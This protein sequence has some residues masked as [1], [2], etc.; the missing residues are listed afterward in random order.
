MC[1]ACAAIFNGLNPDGI[2]YCDCNGCVARWEAMAYTRTKDTVAKS[3][4]HER[5]V[6]INMSSINVCDR[7]NSMVKGGAL[8]ALTIAYSP[9]MTVA[10]K[11]LRA[12][13]C[14]GC[15]EDLATLYNS[16][17]VT[18][19]KSA[20]TEPYDPDV[21][22]VRDDLEGITTEQLAAALLERTMKDP[23]ARRSI[24]S[25]YTEEGNEY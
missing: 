21:K 24:T 13:L 15:I 4:G 10:A 23:S 20:Y 1:S 12:E 11:T 5:A 16:P 8:G 19:R 18:P 22:T 9:D 17:V 25:H 14:P 3:F 7:C 6:N 2:L